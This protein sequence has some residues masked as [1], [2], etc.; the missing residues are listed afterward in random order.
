MPLSAEC[1]TVETRCCIRASRVR[2]VKTQT[3][4]TFESILWKRY[5]P[6][7]TN[8]ESKHVVLIDRIRTLLDII[9]S[10]WDVV[11]EINPF[12]IKYEPHHRIINRG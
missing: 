11:E 7:A 6:A 1:S 3:A 5:L 2:N 8:L 10:D 4:F 12:K 9:Q